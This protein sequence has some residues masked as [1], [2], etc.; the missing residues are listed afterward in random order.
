MLSDLRQ[1]SNP[2]PL[3]VYR[4]GVKMLSEMGIEPKTSPFLEGSGKNSICG[5]NRTLD[6][7]ISRGQAMLMLSEAGIE[8]ETSP[9]L[10]GMRKNAI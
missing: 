5:W 4:T 2:K 3:H 6:V 10:E 8:P 9:F 7:L 1:E